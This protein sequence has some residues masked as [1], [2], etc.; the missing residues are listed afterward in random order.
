MVVPSISRSFLRPLSSV[1]VTTNFLTKGGITH[2]EEAKE[3]TSQVSEV[4]DAASGSSN[5]REE[6]NEAKKDDEIFCRDGEEKIDIDHPVW[7]EPAVGQ[8]QSV[9]GSGRADDRVNLIEGRKKQGANH[10]GDTCSNPADEKIPKE[11]SGTPG[12]LEFPSKHVEGQ[13]IEQD[14]E[15]PAVKKDVGNQLPKEKFLPDENG[16][17]GKPIIKIDL[18]EFSHSLKNEN[19]S[20]DDHQFF[21]DRR[22]SISK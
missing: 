20:H 3:E 1:G 17:E 22:Q 10:C 19:G 4:T 9:D 15:D 16:N 18:A 14:M 2:I 11:L 7:K 5:R 8:K 21:D 12:V 6:F 13:E